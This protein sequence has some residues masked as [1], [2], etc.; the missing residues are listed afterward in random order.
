MKPM[1]LTSANEIPVG[2]EWL[3]E[4]KYDGFRCILVW[5]EKSP[6]FV[7]RNGN[8]LTH[9]FPEITQFYAN[10]YEKFV[11]FLP[12]TADGELVHLVNAYK[13]DFSIVQS[14]GRM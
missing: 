10:I 4:V 5:D 6:T 8:D 13:S 1:L 9:L 7:S 14:R 11:P 3:Y 12:L 2:D